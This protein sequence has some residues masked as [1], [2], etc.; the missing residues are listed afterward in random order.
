MGEERGDRWDGGKEEGSVGEKE[1]GEVVGGGEGELAYESTKIALYTSEQAVSQCQ[2]LATIRRIR[3][4]DWHRIEH[5]YLID[6]YSLWFFFCSSTSCVP[7]VCHLGYKKKYS[8][9]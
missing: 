8:G 6:F 7:S 9:L 4:H 5:H 3:K 1:E 2:M